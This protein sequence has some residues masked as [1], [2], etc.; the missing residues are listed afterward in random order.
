MPAV[1]RLHWT[2]IRASLPFVPQ[3]HSE[4]S[5][6]PY[7]AGQLF[8]KAEFWLAEDESGDLLGYVAF[9]PDFIEHLFIHPAAQNRGV[10]VALL[11]KA[12]ASAA[13]EL[14]LWTFQQNLKA[15]RF[16]ERHGFAATLETDG[17]DNE[18]KL[19]DVLYRWRRPQS[20]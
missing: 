10:G 5:V 4:E 3:V 1:A 8:D 16:Y 12:K 17:A 7:F 13:A 15:R 18:E 2:T 11:E 20:L 19:P 6:E 14:S 9:R